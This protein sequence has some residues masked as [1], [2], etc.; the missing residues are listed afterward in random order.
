[1]GNSTSASQGG[2]TTTHDTGD[3]RFSASEEQ[4][5]WP[6]EQAVATKPDTQSLQ[7]T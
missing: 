3:A 2:S 1:M 5:D 7:E 6:K 4:H